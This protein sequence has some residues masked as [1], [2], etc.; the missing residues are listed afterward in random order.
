MYTNSL[1]QQPIIQLK[2]AFTLIEMIVVIFVL[3]V[4]ILSIVMLITRNLSLTSHIH[5]QNTA[6]ILAR[7]WLELAYNYKNTNELLWYERNC[8]QRQLP[9]TK[10][11]T[12]SN[13]SSNNNCWKYFWSGNNKNSIFT[14][15][16]IK[17]GQSQ[18][19]MKPL[20]DIQGINF[21]SLRKATHLSL[22]W[23]SVWGI[24]FTGY[25]HEAGEETPY[26]RYIEF[27]GMNNIPKNSPL[28]SSDIYHISSTVL[29]RNKNKTGEV[30]LESFISN[31]K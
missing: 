22:T 23:I 5:N 11:D 16:G 26:A 3:W 1:F 14:I 7:E 13:S 21:E 10:K 24:S 12:M 29:Y 30:V 4:G 27:T 9:N 15:E 31:P 25:T 8:A 19:L 17:P 2:K 20:Q 18:V 28:L 6:T